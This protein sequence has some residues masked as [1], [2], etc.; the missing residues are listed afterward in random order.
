[1]ISQQI[2]GRERDMIYIDL[3]EYGMPLQKATVDL[4]PNLIES[5]DN[6]W[7]PGALRR[8]IKWKI[9]ELERQIL[10]EAI[11]ARNRAEKELRQ[12]LFVLGGSV[13]ISIGL[14]LWVVL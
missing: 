1:M 12:G 2:C 10:I 5:L 11:E 7:A 13:A 6:S 3:P 14:I 9:A 8:H 4:I